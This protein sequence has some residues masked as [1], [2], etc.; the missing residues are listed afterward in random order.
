VA[1]YDDTKPATIISK[2]FSGRLDCM[3]ELEKKDPLSRK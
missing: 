2:G 1:F 3:K